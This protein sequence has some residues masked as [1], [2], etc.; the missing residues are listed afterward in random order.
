M[1]L[2]LR[3][4]LR[5]AAE[6]STPGNSEWISITKPQSVREQLDNNLSSELAAIIPLKVM[7]IPVLLATKDNEIRRQ[8]IQSI[9]IDVMNI[10]SKYGIMPESLFSKGY[11]FSDIVPIE[12]R[13][14]IAR[15][16][17]SALQLVGT[18]LRAAFDRILSS[19]TS[20][21]N[22]EVPLS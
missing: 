20:R 17:T 12:A 19:D 2:A 3:R 6:N 11:V 15:G 4:M 9:P 22:E 21:R 13:S 10:L 5:W 18:R 8:V 16:L 1:N 7:D 14:S